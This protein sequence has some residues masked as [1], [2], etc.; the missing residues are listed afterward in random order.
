[1]SAPYTFIADADDAGERVD[2]LLARRMDVPRATAQR[3][4][5]A[6]RVQVDARPARPGTRLAEGAVVTLAAEATPAPEPPV[7]APDVALDVLFEDEAI[8]VLAKPA[9]MVVH[10]GLGHVDDTLVNALAARFPDIAAAFPPDDPRPGI[11]HRLDADTSGVLVVAR[12]PA[13]KEVLQAQFKGRAVDKMYIALARGTVQPPYGLIDAPLGRDSVH[14]QRVAVRPN[15]R[16]AVTGYHVAATRPTDSLLV[17]R[18]FTGRTH[19]I[20]VHLAAVGHPIAGDRV[21]GRADRTLG[22][23]ALHAWALSFAH[24]SSGAPM[25]FIAPLDADLVAEFDRR[26]GPGWPADVE[27]AA[28]ALALWPVPPSVAI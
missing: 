2:V 3:W 17:V 10:P 28:Q 22:R 26:Y 16:E 8:V 12:T 18:L 7:A 9:G 14:R 25:T 13:A 5:G 21:Y 6:G 11:V 19:Q 4:I 27:A 23:M 24:P 15:G 20:R 1:M